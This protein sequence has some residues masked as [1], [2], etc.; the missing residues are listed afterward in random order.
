MRA[1]CSRTCDR[2]LDHSAAGAG[3]IRCLDRFIRRLRQRCRSLVRFSGQSSKPRVALLVARARRIGICA[4]PGA[5]IG[6]RF[7]RDAIDRARRD[8][9]LASSAQIAKYDVHLLRR[10]DD[11]IDRT[12]LNAQGAADAARF[13]DTREPERAIAAA[14]WIQRK[15][16]TTCQCRKRL[17]AGV[18]AR[19]ATIDLGLAGANRFGVRQAAIEAALATLRL[20]QERVD[21]LDGDANLAR[22]RVRA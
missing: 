19:W 18:T 2:S 10:A 3:R 11:R 21:L 5:P 17:D 16:R 7:H 14:A 8:A 20:R 13:V 22:T 12:R 15:R 6:W 1:L 4:V 9:Q